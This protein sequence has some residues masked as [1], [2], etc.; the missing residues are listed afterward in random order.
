MKFKS[1]EEAGKYYE[2]LTKEIQEEISKNKYPN[3]EKVRAK[4]PRMFLPR[5]AAFVKYMESHDD[6]PAPKEGEL[7]ESP[8][9]ECCNTCTDKECSSSREYRKHESI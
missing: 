8:L 9:P 4:I 2:N 6:F 1:L 5:D 7:I 3:C